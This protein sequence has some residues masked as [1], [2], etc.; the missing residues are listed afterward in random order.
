MPTAIRSLRSIGSWLAARLAIVVVLAGLI[1]RVWGL[2]RERRRS[3][4]AERSASRRSLPSLFETYPEATRAPR[5]SLGMR[6]VPI[7]RITGTM[8]HPSQNTADFLPLP[9]L[10]GENWRARWLRIHGA[11]DRLEML[12]PVELVQ[13]GDDYFVAD[14]HNRVAAARET[15]A[16]E[17]DAVVTQLIVPG[18]TQPGQAVA[19]A[20]TLLGNESVRQA[21]VGRLSRTVE[22]RPSADRISRRDL[23]RESDVPPDETNE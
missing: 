19:D 23:L 4:I 20:G 7:D 14:G 2:V 13:V 21:A 16:I 9:R 8:R 1:G 15:G 22:Q 12:P 11:T 17:I 10:R 6:S 3:T 18:I 5:R